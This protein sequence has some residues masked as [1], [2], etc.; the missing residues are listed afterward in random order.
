MIVICPA[1]VA[2]VIMLYFIDHIII[3]H[4]SHVNGELCRRPPP[5]FLTHI[6]RVWVKNR[7][8]IPVNLWKVERVELCEESSEQ[9]HQML[10]INPE[11]K[12]QS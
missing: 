10:V 11:Q 5:Y 2:L 9:N 6:F 8:I 3:R 12:L 4:Q 7:E 1:I